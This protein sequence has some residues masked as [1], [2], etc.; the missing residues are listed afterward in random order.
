MAEEEAATQWSGSKST[1][2]SGCPCAL[3]GL[4]NESTEDGWAA[5]KDTLT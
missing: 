2:K 3:S 1:V 4:K 5:V